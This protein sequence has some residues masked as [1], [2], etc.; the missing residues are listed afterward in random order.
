[1]QHARSWTDITFELANDRQLT[2]S[3]SGDTVSLSQP[4]YMRDGHG[5]RVQWTRAHLPTVRA[6]L[7]ALEALPLLP[8][9][10]AALAN[11]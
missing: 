11:A 1:M 3:V 10:R 9:E 4:G 8:H 7:A 5:F 2:V 6:L